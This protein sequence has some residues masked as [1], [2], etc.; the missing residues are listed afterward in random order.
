MNAPANKEVGMEQTSLCLLLQRFA[1]I[2]LVLLVS[3]CFILD[4]QALTL[5]Y[6]YVGPQ[7]TVPSVNNPPQ[8]PASIGGITITATSLGYGDY[9]YT[10]TAFGVSVQDKYGIITLGTNGEVIE[11]SAALSGRLGAS[12][13]VSMY[14]AYHL[15]LNWDDVT[16]YGYLASLPPTSENGNGMGFDCDYTTTEQGT[17]SGGTVQTP[18]KDIGKPSQNTCPGNNATDPVLNALCGNPINAATGN[19]LQIET[20]FTASPNTGLSLVRYYNSL[21]T[22]GSAFGS[23]WRTTWHR[24]LTV[25]GTTVTVTRADGRQ[26]TFTNNNGVYTADPDVTSVL[27]TTTANGVI[28][29]QLLTASDSTETYAANGTLLSIASRDGLATTLSYNGSNQLTTVT[30]PFGHVMSFAYDSSGRV[31]HMTAPDGG[32][33]AYAYDANNN[34]IAVTYPDKTTR[35]YVYNEQTNTANTNLPHAL[36]GIIDEL[37]NRFAT[38]GYNAQGAA[39]SSQHAGGAELTTVSYGDNASTVTDANGNVHTYGFTTL[40]NMIKPVSLTG[41]PIPSLGGNAFSYDANGFIASKTDYDYNVTTYTHDA[42]GNQTS[43]TEATGTAQARTI[44]TTW[45]PTFHLPTQITEPNRVTTLSYDSHGNLTQKT[46]ADASNSKNTRTWSYTYNANGQVT[47]ADGPR[48]DVADITQYSYDAKGDLASVTDALGHV[49]AIS[50]YD[51]DGRP[52]TLQDPNGLI[53]QL[54]YDPRGRLLSRNTGGET[55]AYS[56]D[57]A[58]QVLKITKPDASFA[59]FSYDPAHRLTQVS[60][61]LGNKIVYTLDANDNQTKK[62]VYDP[63][64]TLTRSLGQTFDAVNRLQTSVGAQGQTTTYGYDS[65]GNLTSVTDPLSKATIRYFDALNRL[66]ASFDRLA[67]KTQY[68]F[69]ANDNLAQITDQRSANTVYTYDGLGNKTQQTSPDTGITSYTYDAVG[70]VI[71]R[72]DA[73]GIQTLYSYDALNRLV[74]KSFTPNNSYGD[75]SSAT[76]QYDQGKYGIGHLTGMTDTSGASTWLYEIHGRVV[77]QQQISGLITLTTNYQYDAAGR[78]SQ[79]TTP[80]NHAIAYQYNANGQVNAVTVGG[81]VLFN[82]AQYQPFGPISSWV[83][84]NGTAYKRSYDLDG[85]LVTLPLG[86]DNRSLTYDAASRISGETSDATVQSVSPSFITATT[87]GTTNYAIKPTG[88]ALLSETIANG[89]VFNMGYDVVGNLFSDSFYTYQYDLGGRLMTVG[90]D[91]FQMDGLGKRVAKVYLSTGNRYFAYDKA[92]HLLGEYNAQGLAI[93]ETIWL[94]DT[95]VG[96]VSAGTGLLYVYAD[97]LNT[98]RTVTTQSNRVLWSWVSDPFGNGAPITS[99]DDA[100]NPYQYNLRFPGQYYDA[101]TGLHYNMAR[102]YNPAIGRYTQSDPIGLKGGINT[103]TYVRNNPIKFIDNW[104]FDTFTEQEKLEYLV[105]LFT[106][107][108]YITTKTLQHYGLP[109]TTSDYLSGGLVSSGTAMLTQL[110][111]GASAV[112]ILKVGAGEFIPGVSEA[113]VSTQIA[114]QAVNFASK[115]CNDFQSQNN[116]ISQSMIDYWVEQDQEEHQVFQY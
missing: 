28:T 114:N 90:S 45:H 20:D 10:I 108:D 56:Y 50:A 75:I 21:D 13:V 93:Q 53:T 104:G 63:S 84:G 35:H 74:K 88:N 34:P 112:T 41:V 99:N 11:S 70:N 5:T 43:R 110:N 1:C 73:R 55:T 57:A 101:E 31:V 38:W 8:C 7:L 81:T 103:Y 109:E 14:E 25:S 47:Q 87:A 23:N 32:V 77:Q 100:G 12:T 116:A 85:R 40:F 80:A 54:A 65:N 79:L 97:H 48:T 115:V 24:A 106:P 67:D 86:T 42:R 71:T 111:F 60:D 33:Y 4:A 51:A 59:A 15:N 89:T 91:S 82:A 94:G 96:T 58:G 3:F 76:Y 66:I 113:Y 2:I 69:D 17:W 61:N 44:T 95:P 78:L 26:D 29:Y 105:G 30:G 6:N 83:W 92:G 52:L 16:I 72:T 37:G 22:G 27:T 49:T 62:Q 102:Y 68:Q 98:P 19:K 107:W 18:Q 39:I 9:S 46:I 36:T 64:G